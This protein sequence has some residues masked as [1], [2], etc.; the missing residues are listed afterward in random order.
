[1][2]LSSVVKPQKI[3]AV[4]AEVIHQQLL[5]PSLINMGGVQDY[6]GADND[7]IFIKV[8]GYLPADEIADWRAE[9]STPLTLR[10]FT[11][12]KVS[13]TFGGNTYSAT[14][15]QDEQRDF[16]LL[17]W[18][19]V[20][21]VQADAIARKMNA[22]ALSLVKPYNAG[23]NPLGTPFEITVA[24]AA[25]ARSTLRGT[26]GMR[27]DLLA[28]VNY[29]D[30]VGMPSEGRIFLVGSA[31]RD[32]LL[33][34]DKIV[35]SQNTSEATAEAAL[36][37]ANIGRILGMDV[38][39]A[40]ELPSDFGVLFVRDAFLMR[41]AA[42]SL[43]ASVGFGATA[44]AGPVDGGNAVSVRWLRDYDS[45][46]L[47]ERSVL[48]LYNGVNYTKD[49]LFDEANNQAAQ[50][51]GTVFEYVIRAIAWD[52]DATADVTPTGSVADDRAD[53]F[54]RVTGVGTRAA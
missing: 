30:K 49:I 14:K 28:L 37:D 22:K 13:I 34:D 12:R 35:L 51:S 27:A 52:M 9:R 26:K 48:N 16:D 17:D 42:P 31:T 38:V 47:A 33:L 39:Y 53:T 2:T 41:T 6:V 10:A 11:E 8:P 18:T 46:I 5:I 29:A 54:A 24:G 21:S 3:A 20:V 44:S 4:A 36:R 32:A 19:K 15:L 50:A 40:K 7:T 1:M 43:P 25:S 23:T 45:T